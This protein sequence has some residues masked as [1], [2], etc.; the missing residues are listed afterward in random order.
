MFSGEWQRGT[1]QTNIEYV[2][3]EMCDGYYVQSMIMRRRMVELVMLK[4]IDRIC[5][6]HAI[7]YFGWYGTL[8]GAVRHRGFIPWDD[9]MHLAMLR[10]DCERTAVHFSRNDRGHVP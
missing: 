2:Q 7:K 1:V 6:S 9:D 5:R 4:E 3:S 8:L 10:K